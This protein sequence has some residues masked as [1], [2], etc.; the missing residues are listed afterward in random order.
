MTT[1]IY[2]RVSTDDQTLSVEAQ[3]ATGLKYA[4]MRELK[5][6]RIYTDIAVS[7][8]VPLSKR[9]QGG[10]LA[11]DLAAGDVS[12]VVA[13]RLDRLF[14]DTADALLT[15]QAWDKAG[16]A[17][18]LVDMGGAAVDVS[19]P[20]GRLM[21]T[22]LAG[23]A[24]FERSLTAERTAAALSQKVKR[25]EYTGGDAPWGYA[26]PLGYLQKVPAE[27]ALVKR[28]KRYRARD[29]TWQAIADR[30]NKKPA[31]QNRG[32]PWRTDTLIRR[33]G[34]FKTRPLGPISLRMTEV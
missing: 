19:S 15:L 8:S 13:I 23:I 5:D 12:A 21:M 9:P 17:L 26:A 28:V 32:R 14:R 24:Q 33:I 4:A 18:H 7:G 1:A 20:I 31:S 6:C 3:E 27:L 34:G 30:L 11:S 29:W 2:I 22:F 25:G 10:R 16:V